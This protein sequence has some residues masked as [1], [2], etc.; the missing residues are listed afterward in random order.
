MMRGTIINIQ[1]YSIHDGPG[2]RTT[3]FFKGCPL[4]CWWCHNPE[5]QNKSKE[6]MYWKDKC[7]VCGM[8]VKKCSQAAIELKDGLLINDREKCIACGKCVDF[9]S[10]NAREIV[11]KEVSV[12][13]VIKEVEKDIIFYEESGGGVTFSGGEPMFQY[14][15]LNELIDICKT[16]GIHTAVDTTGF[17]SWDKLKEI[18]SKADLF[19][20]DLK[21]M[22]SKKHKKYTG[23]DNEIILN[24]LKKLSIIHN[25]IYVRIPIIPGINDDEDNL[26]RSAE[27]LGQL[28]IKKVNLLP[29][30]KYGMDKYERLKKSYKLIDKEEPSDEIMSEISEYF[31]KSGLNVKI[32]G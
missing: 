19:L 25:N 14:E 3:V 21:T 7:T 5:S 20:Y 11:G 22:D 8:C 23:V 6:L 17:T 9:C 10:N 16:K 28:R 18:A 13:E 30:H 1:K 27:F 12:R 15:F 4:N 29:Y 24:N 31:V 26:K 2:I 32:G